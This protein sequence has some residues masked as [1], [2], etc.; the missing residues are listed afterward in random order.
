MFKSFTAST[1]IILLKKYDCHFMYISLFVVLLVLF[2]NPTNI[3]I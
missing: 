2:I 3:G 1:N